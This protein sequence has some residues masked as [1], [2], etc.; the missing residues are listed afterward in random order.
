MPRGTIGTIEL[1]GT[2]GTVQ[3]PRILRYY[4]HVFGYLHATFA[5]FKVTKENSMEMSE[6]QVVEDTVKYQMYY[7]DMNLYRGWFCHSF[8]RY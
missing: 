7:T 6:H 5:L 2:T 8:L 4:D 3:Y 1:Q